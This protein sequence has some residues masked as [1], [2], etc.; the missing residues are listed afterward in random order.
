MIRD[1]IMREGWKKRER[2]GNVVRKKV[3]GVK[4]RWGYDK[5]S[6]SDGRVEEKGR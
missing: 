5:M 3:N 6:H 2:E 4:G 1:D